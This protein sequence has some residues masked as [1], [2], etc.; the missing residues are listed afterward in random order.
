MIDIDA[1]WDRNKRR[2]EDELLA[3][4]ADAAGLDAAA[5]ARIAD[6][7]TALV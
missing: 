1:R 6:R 3:A 7:A 2:P 5:R 4:L